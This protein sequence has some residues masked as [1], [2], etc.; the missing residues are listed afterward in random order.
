MIEKRS[1]GRLAP[2]ADATVLDLQLTRDAARRVC[3]SFAPAHRI[4]IPL[5]S[6]HPRSV[7]HPLALSLALRP[8]PL[9]P[10]F[11]LRRTR[12]FFGIDRVRPY[13]SPR[14]RP[15]RLSVSFLPFINTHRRFPPV[16]VT[17]SRASPPISFAVAPFRISPYYAFF[18]SSR[19]QLVRLFSVRFHP[20]PLCPRV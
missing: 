18:H 15:P 16:T 7:S 8:F 14:N 13:P 19:V 10:F 2:H 6:W 1:R 3:A 12:R 5:R 11:F 9:L 4:L 20:G 17:P